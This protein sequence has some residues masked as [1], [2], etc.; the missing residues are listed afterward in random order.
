MKRAPYC[1]PALVAVIAVLT[2]F[3]QAMA[4][5]PKTV[6]KLKR[7]VAAA[8][9]DLKT[10]GDKLIG[11][12]RNKEAELAV[13]MLDGIRDSVMPLA[14]PADAETLRRKVLTRAIVG[15]WDRPA[16]PDR[17]TFTADGVAIAMGPVGNELVR[18]RV[19]IVSGE[20]AEVTWDSGYIWT[21]YVAGSSRLAVDEKR[22]NDFTNDG[23]VLS[24]AR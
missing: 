7:I 24:R 15:I 2:L 18:G 10:E 23:I 1:Q 13:K 19:R 5:D 8:E 22:G 3:S 21:M 20:Q 12:G 9:K 4:Q 14:E 16:N 6:A 17:Y 11:L